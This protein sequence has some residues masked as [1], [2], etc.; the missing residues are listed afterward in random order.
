MTPMS[1]RLLRRRPHGTGSQPQDKAFE[2]QRAGGRHRPKAP[3]HAGNAA[4]DR[5]IMVTLAFA[6]DIV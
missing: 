6:S 3:P 1:Q 4:S 5:R 2:E